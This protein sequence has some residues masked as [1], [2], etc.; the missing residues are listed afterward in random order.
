M[1][2]SLLIPQTRNTKSTLLVILELY[3]VPAKTRILDKPL[4]LSLILMDKGYMY[5]IISGS[6]SQAPGMIYA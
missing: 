5:S 1:Y 3:T 2:A 6:A 4:F